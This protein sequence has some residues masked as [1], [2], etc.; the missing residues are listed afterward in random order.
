MVSADSNRLYS[1]QVD[2]NDYRKFYTVWWLKLSEHR[3]KFD[4]SW[5]FNISVNKIAV[6]VL[7]IFIKEMLKANR[8][9]K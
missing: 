9:G 6:Y 8:K 5:K 1:N 7:F 2:E 4:M 3:I